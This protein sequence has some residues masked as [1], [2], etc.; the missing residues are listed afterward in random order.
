MRA[1]HLVLAALLVLLAAACGGGDGEAGGGDELEVTIESPSDGEQVSV[2]FTLDLS[3]SVE[4]GPPDSG[5]HHVHVYYD[6]DEEDYAVV[7]SDSY[8]VAGLSPGEH[9]INVSLRNADHSAAGAETEI[10]VTVVGGGA[11]GSD[12]DKDGGY[13]Y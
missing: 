2:P 10:A 5:D 9:T 6:G 12:E 3:S 1:R 11:P 13:D 8:E 4:L 7:E